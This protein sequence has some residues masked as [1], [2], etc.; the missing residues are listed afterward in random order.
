MTNNGRLYLV[1]D[2]GEVLIGNMSDIKRESNG[3]EFK[4]LLPLDHKVLKNTFIT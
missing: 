2:K 1:L 3:F 4:E